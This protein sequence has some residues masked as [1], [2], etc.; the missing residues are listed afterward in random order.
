M[1]VGERRD[2]RTPVLRSAAL[3]QPWRAISRWTG[4][5]SLSRSF[6]ALGWGGREGARA[7]QGRC[8][9]PGRRARPLATWR[10]YRD[11]Q[12]S[13][14]QQDERG[15]LMMLEDAGVPPSAA[16]KAGVERLAS[17]LQRTRRRA[18]CGRNARAGYGQHANSRRCR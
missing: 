7:S 16:L 10:A 14:M 5:R 13:G 11:R 12:L 6:C 2:G 15:F 1:G 17:I 9:P 18:A 3:K 8:A 4:R